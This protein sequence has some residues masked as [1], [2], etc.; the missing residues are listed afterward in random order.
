MNSEDKYGKF[1]GAGF[2][3][4]VY[5]DHPGKH[6]GGNKDD[7]YF[8]PI[9]RLLRAGYLRLEGLILQ[10]VDQ[11][12]GVYKRVGKFSIS[13]EHDCGRFMDTALRYR[14]SQERKADKR[15]ESQELGK[16]GKTIEII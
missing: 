4:D 3:V 1:C 5:L 6:F 2:P 8:L 10:P 14:E 16:L 13:N 9:T 7:V 12:D 11:G 15:R